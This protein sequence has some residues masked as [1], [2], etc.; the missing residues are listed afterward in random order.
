MLKNL[1]IPTL[2]LA[3]VSLTPLAAQEPPRSELE[4][5]LRQLQSEVRELQRQ[6][7]EGRRTETRTLVTPRA[8]RAP[9]AVRISTNRAMLG[10]TVRTERSARVDSI[11]AELSGVTPGGPADRAG[12]RSGDIIVSFNGERLASRYPAAGEYESE[13]G[14]KLVHFARELEEGDTVQVEYRRDRQSAKA[15]IVARR[16]EPSD[17]FGITVDPPEVYVETDRLRDMAREMGDGRFAFSFGFDQWLDMELVALNAD[18]GEYFGTTEG[19][20]VVR[21][22]RDAALNLKAGDVIVQIGN[23]TPTSQASAIRILRSYGAGEQVQF[24]IMRQK[25]RQTVTGTVP[26]RDRDQDWR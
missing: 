23:R 7:N 22:P 21:P 15:T 20:L 16:M 19:L 9:M 6:L 8:P 5:R 14:M 10:V 24:E 11:G 3:L 17:W 18:L 26:D 1:M 25:R 2:A 12:L 13:P 4:E